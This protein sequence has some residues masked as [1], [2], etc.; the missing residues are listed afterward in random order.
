MTGQTTWSELVSQPDA[1]ERLIARL[2]AGTDVP[3][4]DLGSYDEVMMLGSGTSYYLALAAADWVKRRHAVAVS[5]VPSCEVIL[6]DQY[7]LAPGRTRL[8]IG[9]S[10]SGESSELILALGALR[11]EG[12]TVMG[13]SCSPGS[14][15]LQ[16]ADIPFFLAEGQEDGLVMLRSFTSMLIALQ[17]LAGTGEDRAALRT[18]PAAARAL[19]TTQTDALRTLAHGRAF[20]RFVY[21]A[22]GPSYP[23]ALEASLKVQEMSISTSEAYHSLEYLHGP[24]ANAD[25]DTFLTLFALADEALGLSLARDM[26]ALGVTLLVVGPG[27]DRY[28]GIADMVAPAPAGLSEA[29]ASALS[30]LPLQIL[31]YETAMRKGKNPDAPENLSKVVILEPAVA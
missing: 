22:S 4:L 27:A 9:F 8:V 13:L 18:L 20:D 5:A 3:T 2:D 15:L 23:I 31:G 12:T 10:R 26:K 14:T 7:R 28:A 24:K 19:L 29:A 21:L 11:G 16:R 25:A 1:W 17:Y 30:L 6:D